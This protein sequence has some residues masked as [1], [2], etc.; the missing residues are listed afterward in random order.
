MAEPAT[1][2]TSAASTQKKNSNAPPLTR[3]DEPFGVA[4]LALELVFHGAP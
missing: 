2:A 1:T 3:C 4:R